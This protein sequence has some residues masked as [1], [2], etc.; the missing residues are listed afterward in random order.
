MRDI[1]RKIIPQSTTVL[2]LILMLSCIIL[3]A[4]VLYHNQKRAASEKSMIS[5]EES[6]VPISVSEVV[7][8]DNQFE[9]SASL[10]T[11]HLLPGDSQTKRFQVQVSYQDSITL[12]F[13]T[14][15]RSGGEKLSEVMKIKVH[16]P[17]TG[18]LLYDGPIV[19]MP[20]LTHELTS[21]KKVTQ[22]I[23]YDVTVYLDPSADQSYQDLDFDAG[24]HWWASETD[25]LRSSVR[26]EVVT[27]LLVLAA[28]ITGALVTTV[29]IE[30]QKDRGGQIH[31]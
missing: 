7:L 19:T 16:L 24:L 2:A 20:T 15:I 6:A 29:L 21:D 30:E 25:N 5:G 31:A 26:N 22:N 13:D 12:C 18:E 3:I 28:T 9:N 4:T 17:S 27:A 14:A 11:A 1:I 23:P 8:S 10:Y